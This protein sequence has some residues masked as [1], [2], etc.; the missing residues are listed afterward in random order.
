MQCVLVW[1]LHKLLNLDFILIL[2]LTKEDTERF[3]NYFY[4]WKYVYIELNRYGMWRIE[5]EALN[6]WSPLFHWKQLLSNFANTVICLVSARINTW[7][8]YL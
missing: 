1:V 5:W 6:P 2:F 3:S 8:K 4:R 7:N